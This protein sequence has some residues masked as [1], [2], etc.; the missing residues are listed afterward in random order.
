MVGDPLALLDRRDVEAGSGP[1]GGGR[2]GAGTTPSLAQASMARISTSSQV[3]EAGL[4][5]EQVRHWG[6]GVAV[7][8]GGSSLP[9]T[10]R[11]VRPTPRGLG[12]C[13][14]LG[15]RLTETSEVAGTM[16]AEQ[17][18]RVSWELHEA[19]AERRRRALRRLRR[20][21][22]RAVPRPADAEASAHALH[23]CS[24]VAAGVRRPG[25]GAAT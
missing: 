17:Q 3:G 20:A 5:G 13:A 16:H 24:L 19:L 1:D 23:P 8:Q 22:V 10:L 12:R 9:N 7:D 14:P 2:V 21:L 15:E 11:A 25:R 18:G 6:E 4:V